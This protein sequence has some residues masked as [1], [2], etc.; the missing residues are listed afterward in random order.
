[1]A[2]Q[3][4][5]DTFDWIQD[6]ISIYLYL[7]LYKGSVMPKEML[8]VGAGRLNPSLFFP[9]APSSLFFA[10]ALGPTIDYIAIHAASRPA[11]TS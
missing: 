5:R 7:G 4:S 8:E 9:P 11:L 3:F 10:F 1:M 2:S 6:V